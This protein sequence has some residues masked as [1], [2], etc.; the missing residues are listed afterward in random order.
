MTFPLVHPTF[1]TSPIVAARQSSAFG[2][3]V[4]V[5]VE[6]GLRLSPEASANLLELLRGRSLFLN[7]AHHPHQS[8][9]IVFQGDSKKSASYKDKSLNHPVL[10]SFIKSQFVP[11]DDKTFQVQRVVSWIE[12][13]DFSR[14]DLSVEFPKKFQFVLKKQLV[15]KFWKRLKP[16]ESN[17]TPKLLP[18]YI[19][20]ELVTVS[21]QHSYLQGRGPRQPMLDLRC[22]RAS[23]F[24]NPSARFSFDGPPTKLKQES[25]LEDLIRFLI[26]PVQE[27]NRFL[28]GKL[29]KYPV[30]V[31]EGCPLEVEERQLLPVMSHREYPVFSPM[32]LKLRPD[33][34]CPIL[35]QIKLTQLAFSMQR[36]LTDLAVAKLVA[37]SGLEE[38]G[39]PF[40]VD[41]LIRDRNLRLIASYAAALNTK[42]HVGSQTASFRHL[43]VETRFARVANS[44]GERSDEV[45]LDRFQSMSN[46]QIE[47]VTIKVREPIQRRDLYAIEFHTYD[48]ARRRAELN[49]FGD[50]YEVLRNQSTA[51][52]GE[53]PSKEQ[54]LESLSRS[55]AM[56][57]TVCRRI[58]SHNLGAN[59]ISELR[60]KIR[61]NYGG[62][63]QALAM[64]M[65][66]KAFEASGLYYWSNPSQWGPLSFATQ[67]SFTEMYKAFIAARKIDHFDAIGE[68]RWKFLARLPKAL[69]ENDPAALKVLTDF[70]L[71]PEK[72]RVNKSKDASKSQQFRVLGVPELAVSA[73]LHW[74]FFPTSSIE[75]FI[76]DTSF[77]PPELVDAYVRDHGHVSKTNRAL[78]ELLVS[79]IKQF[80]RTNFG[81]DITVPRVLHQKVFEN[82]DG[83]LNGTRVTLADFS[84]AEAA[85]IL[86]ASDSGLGSKRLAR[87]DPFFLL[88][89]KACGTSTDRTV[90]ARITAT[91]KA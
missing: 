56:T 45:V 58:L 30:S 85:N 43:D 36:T 28:T 65:M 52:G 53:F 86:E 11:T 16:T 23:Y 62:N 70:C 31:M 6:S 15:T 7:E 42:V 60:D 91:E 29:V 4:P 25:E 19:N 74:Y 17:P 38:D 32:E 50:E 34:E 14:A 71:R 41:E 69:S 84:Y 61:R 39:N 37:Q 20:R 63:V 64:S 77:F 12:V 9:P 81:V 76:R 46:Q 75:D 10:N 44:W 35:H 13:T 21:F 33:L 48:M 8:K 66:D 27:L 78:I 47:A 67:P 2:D 90:Q 22:D 54:R 79:D 73:L 82:R 49:K 87:T 59:S 3:D 57:V 89:K 18:Y 40:R 51:L 83:A 24:N 88:F 72:R 5:E 68:D 26:F 1:T 55:I 80:C